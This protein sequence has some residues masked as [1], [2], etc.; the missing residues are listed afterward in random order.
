[1]RILKRLNRRDAERAEKPWKQSRRL[2]FSLRSLRL[3][4]CLCL[5]FFVPLSASA[6][7]GTVYL[8]LDTG[9]MRHAELIAEILKRQQ[10]KATFFLANEKTTQGDYAL[11]AHWAAYWKAR[12]A[13][14]HAFGSHTWNHGVFSNDL[15]QGRVHYRPLFGA[16]A[17]KTLV[18][19]TAAVCAELDHVNRRFAEMTGQEL[20]GYW[21]APGG[22]T[23]PN[24]LAAAQSCGYQHAG[25]SPAGFLGDELPSEKFSNQMLLDKALRD[26]RTGD[27]LLAHLGIWSRK[28]PF[29]PM[30][31]PLIAALKQRGFCFATL[32]E[33]PAFK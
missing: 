16:Q 3:C 25:W 11:D 8:T 22:H 14:G 26:I 30:L 1:M 6:C 31:E 32:R 33:H 12:A 7:T 29:A 10:I 2:R 5:I 9:N 20:D 15:P 21:R 24:A 19:D 13:E 17:G 27:I 18:L 28:D 23:T 4:G